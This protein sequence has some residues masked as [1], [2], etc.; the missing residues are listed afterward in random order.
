MALNIKSLKDGTVPTSTIGD[1][2]P[3]V[4]DGKSVI[5]KNM[6][7]VNSGTADATLN[8][9]FTGEGQRR[10]LPKD[11]KLPVGFSLIEEQEITMEAGDK[12]EGLSTVAN[13]DYVISGIERE[14]A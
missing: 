11:L 7:F 2:L 1:V 5:V 10:I 9:Y 6:R 4:G 13:V 14:V 8:V 3:A 12:I